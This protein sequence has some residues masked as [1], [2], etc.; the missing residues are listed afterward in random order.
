MQSLIL[1]IVLGVCVLGIISACGRPAATP[2][3]GG[4]VE[5]RPAATVSGAP[6]QPSG[7][8]RQGPGAV[9]SHGGAVR[10]HVTFVDY[11]RSQGLT[12]EIVGEV[13]QPFLRAKGTRLR[14]SGGELTRPAEIQSYHYDDMELK[15]NGVETAATDANGIA[16]DGNPKTMRISW[17]ATPHFFHRER[18][19]V[20]YLG[21]DPAVL[22]L[23]TKALGQQ[24]AGG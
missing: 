23:L 24:F 21:D 7:E 6:T 14:V 15:A 12:V 4:G 22:A 20:L 11:L 13:Q 10:D 9:Q 1:R 2:L 8:A 16:P 5:P 18:I 19:I 17:V 3:A